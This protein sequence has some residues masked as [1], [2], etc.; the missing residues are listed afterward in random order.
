MW[1]PVRLIALAVTLGSLALAAVVAWAVAGTPGTILDEEPPVPTRR[2]PTATGMVIIPVEQGDTARDIGERLEE[3]GVIQSA[4][5]FRVLVALTGV[6]DEL[7]DGEY[8]FDRGLATM[9]VINRIHNGLTAPLIV[10]IPEGL[11]K[12]EIADLLERKGIIP[13][14]E[15]RTA[16]SA[17]VYDASFLDLLPSGVGLEGFLFPA[18]YG[19][20]RNATG[21]DV[22]SEMLRAFDEKVMP[23]LPPEGALDLT[24]HEAV[25]LASIVEREAVIPRERP[26]IASVYLNRLQIGLPLQADPTVQYAVA[27]DPD[28]V[29]RFGYW[30]KELT[31]ADLALESPYNTYVRVG[32]PPG[33]IANPGLDS[34]QAVVRP[35]RTNYLFF[36][37]Q[38]DGSHVFAET[39]EEHIRNVCAIDPA[40]PECEATPQ[41]GEPEEEER[42]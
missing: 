3:E 33:P 39:L 36:V 31:V 27:N 34:I 29:E 37:A 24:L 30:K 6:E 23:I 12:E 17:R 42:P 38:E 14:Q 18:T 20:S 1:T 2:A 11:R 28:S 32:L 19:F 8:E 21:E 40:R 26:T 16:L 35:A 22:V 4:R 25:T 10:T 9:E 15:F 41:P 7:V 13:A 5:L